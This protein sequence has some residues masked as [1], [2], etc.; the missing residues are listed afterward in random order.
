VQVRRALETLVQV[1]WGQSNPSFFQMVTNLYIP[2]RSTP[3]DQNWFKDLQIKSVS[4]VNLVNIMRACDEINVRPVLSSISV[5][6]AVFHSDRDRVAPL[7]EGRI[8]AAEIPGARFIPL[9]SG[10][11]LL[12]GEEPAWQVFREELG[13]FLK[14]KD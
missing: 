2:D 14:A 4:P 1:N 12:L 10:N 11:H 9:S 5:P 3:E 8:L 7:H 6:T 13:S